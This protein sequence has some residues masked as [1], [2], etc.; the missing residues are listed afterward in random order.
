[1]KT[2]S[3]ESYEKRRKELER[4]RLCAQIVWMG[5][6]QAFARRMRLIQ[7]GLNWAHSQ[8]SQSITPLEFA[9]MYYSEIKK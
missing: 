4:S 7:H 8:E 9:K 2:R 6:P 5:N 3:M 1:M